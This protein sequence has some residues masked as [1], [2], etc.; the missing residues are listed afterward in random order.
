ML[1]EPLKDGHNS[2]MEKMT[3]RQK[4]EAAL[5]KHGTREIPAVICYEGIYIRDH[6]NQ[7]TDHPWWYQQSPDT[8]HQIAWRSD[9][10]DRTGQDWF[11]L[12]YSYSRGH[13][14]YLSIEQRPEGVFLV[15]R[16]TG[17]EDMLT[18]PQ[19]AGWSMSGGLHSVRP[20]RL[21]ETTEEIDL[22]ISIPTGDP[23]N[24]E[25]DG[26]DDLAVSLLEGAGAGLY[27]ICHVGSP[28]WATY[29]LWGFE[30][31]M[32]MVATR[33]DLVKY[34]CQRHLSRG[35]YSVRAAAAL[36]A[37]GIWIEECMTDM[38]SPE[39]FAS[40]CLPFTRSLVDEIRSAGL[41]SIYYFCGNPAGKWDLLLSAGA[42]AISLEESKKAFVIDI[43]DVVEIVKG[44]CT[45]LGNLD[46][47]NLL[48]NASEQQLR[49]E[50]SRQIAAGRRNDSR[51]VM[52]LGSPVTP[53]T[54]VRKVRL[55]CDLVHELGAW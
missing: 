33:P 36:G 5:S 39:A 44:R 8:E 46:A 38:I 4:I 13:R 1:Q 54:L 53:G 40:L 7:L 16:R 29:S 26:A 30:G 17:R 10:I 21:A 37:A 41:R 15:D 49:A 55:Y 25:P 18:K 43:E 34:A 32:I 52:S 50:I 35:V 23:R 45:V 47:I 12:P 3:G 51:F 14:K 11:A 28:L 42:D 24:A 9:V 2:R 22:L 48:P 27:P 19:V 20:R 6:W 31:M